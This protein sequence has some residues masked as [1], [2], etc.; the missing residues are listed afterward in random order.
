M[1]IIYP[2]LIQIFL[3]S[4]FLGADEIKKWAHDSSDLKPDPSV[5]FGTLDNGLRYAIMPN[6]EPPNRIS[7]R[8]FVDAGSLM[9][10]E[11]QQG[12]AHFIEHM[13]FNGTKNFPA[14]E[15]V[16]YF[17]RLGM[18]FGGDTNAHTSFKETVYKL[19]LPKPELDMVDQGMLL[20]RDYADGMLMSQ[21][22][23]EKER[24]VILSEL[25]TRDSAEWRTQKEAYKFALPDSL[26]S[27]RFPIGTK[28]VIKGAGRTQFISYYKKWYT[29]DRMA[30]IV[31]GDVES[32]KIVEVIKK[33]F[34][35]IKAPKVPLNDPELGSITT[36]RGIITKTHY[37]KEASETS[38]SIEVVKP[39]SWEPDDSSKNIKNLNLMIA[40]SIINNRISEI[41]KKEGALIT[42]GGSYAQ[43]FMNFAKFASIY[44]T[45]EP[46]K[47]EGALSVA[48][49]EIRRVISHGFNDAEFKEVKANL[50]N[51]YEQANRSSG[52]RKSRS[53]ADSLT[54]S[55]SMGRV[56]SSPKQDLDWVK[57]T[58]KP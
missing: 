25:I 39:H 5:T 40:N 38:V 26:I 17:Q 42:G 23:I 41:T 54:R 55:I 1:K 7:M 58:S 3:I 48:E 30:I 51:A 52:S 19:E 35:S 29:P 57:K 18:S 9:E 2:V 11:E 14:G 12:L 56:F 24:G 44:V 45:C 49:Q 27:K 10:N 47:W 21:E 28:E 32:D 22:E 50:L 20:F 13:A 36:G 4:S 34:S 8:L 43:E 46:D 53:L 33:H 37:E 6:S 16:E 31:V 15:M